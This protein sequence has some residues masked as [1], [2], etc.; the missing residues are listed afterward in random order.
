MV[1]QYKATSIPSQPPNPR[2]ITQQKFDRGVISL[3]SPA[4]LPPNAL[5]RADNMILEEDGRPKQRPGTNWYGTTLPAALDGGDFFTAT[6]ESVHLIAIAGGTVYR[7][8]DDG[9]T[10]DTC[11]GGSFTVGQKVRS[12]Q[13]DNVL[14]MYDKQ[15]YTLR[16]TGDITLVV[17]TPLLT[18]ANPNTTITGLAGTDVV[19]YTYTISGVNEVGYTPASSLSY[20]AQTNVVAVDRDRSSWDDTNYV[21][22]TWLKGLADFNGN[23]V[24]DAT[25]AALLAASTGPFP[26]RYDIYL[27]VNGGESQYMDSVDTSG[28]AGNQT[29]TYVDKGQSPQFSSVLAPTENTTA[30]LRVGDMCLVS[31]RLFATDDMDFPFRVWISGEGVDIGKFSSAFSG[32]FIDLQEGGQYRPVKVEDYR[33]GKGTPFATV[34]RKSVDG[35]G[36]IWQGTIDTFTVGDTSFPVPNFYKLPGSRGTNAPDSVVNVLND[37]YYYNQQA[38]YNLGSRAQF[39]NLLSTDE[40]SANIRPDVRSITATASANITAYFFEAK[41]YFSVPA[42]SDV[43]NRI[44]LYDT[45][46]RAWLPKAFD[47]GVE[48]FLQYTDTHGGL[49]LLCWKP[50]DSRFSEISEAIKGDYG[51]AFVTDMLTGHVYVNFKNRFDFLWMEE[52]E[53]ELSDVDGDIDIELLGLTREDG[54]ATIDTVSLTRPT[55]PVGWTR[56]AWTKH[57]WSAGSR[58][59]ITSYSEPTTKRYFNVQQDVNFYQYHITSND[60]NARYIVRTLQVN[61]TDTDAGKP[62]EW[63]M[64]S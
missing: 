41:V 25:D 40:S 53:F 33:D 62:R 23:G 50:G 58:T 36:D 10:W 55:A 20:T 1:M 11:T 16:Y 52:G 34:W 45:E 18:P 43:N 6:D 38:F 54:Y 61:G 19:T 46:R 24:I 5:V 2:P 28:I 4:N 12:L 59:A 15:D 7:S 27:S 49:H 56:G 17:S 44:I 42:S 47:F 30:G 9:I 51:E 21:T 39:L 31:T 13:I 60:V 57:A 48:R 32:T 22:L 35:R 37:Y 64:L 29:V 14:Y 3:V 63:E 26:I 8:L